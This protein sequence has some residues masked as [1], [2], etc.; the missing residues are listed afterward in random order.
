[1]KLYFLVLLL[2][3]IE[4][5]LSENNIIESDG[6]VKKLKDTTKD[7]KEQKKLIQKKK[8]KLLNKEQNENKTTET[9]STS[10]TTQG[11]V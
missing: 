5:G 4:S 10:T 8:A 7:T 1:M 2:W 3:V 6:K 11:N 9:P